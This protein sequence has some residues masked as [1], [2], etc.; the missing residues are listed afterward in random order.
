MTSLAS[1]RSPC[2]G[3]QRGVA[4]R[5]RRRGRAEGVGEPLH[6][7]DA[8]LQRLDQVLVLRSRSGPGGLSCSAGGEVLALLVARCRS[9][10]DSRSDAFAPGV[11]SAF[12][13]AVPSVLG[14]VRD[15]RDLG[16]VAL[17]LRRASTST[18]TTGSAGR[19]RRGRATRTTIEREQAQDRASGRAPGRTAPAHARCRG[20]RGAAGGRATRTGPRSWPARPRR[21]RTGCRRRA[22]SMAGESTAFVRSERKCPGGTVEPGQCPRRRSRTTSSSAG[23]GRCAPWARAGWATSGSRATSGAASTSR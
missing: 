2:C 10:V 9:S 3:E 12:A 16:H 21:S 22:G 13:T 17:V 7:A 4:R 6:A 20:R 5:L 15:R 14:A 23:T 11:V 19:R 18:R 8:Q 1:S